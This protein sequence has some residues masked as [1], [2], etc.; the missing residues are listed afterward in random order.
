[1]EA[2]E[3]NE[4]QV[5]TTESTM[6]MRRRG[7]LIPRRDAVGRHH[8]SLYQLSTTMAPLLAPEYL[9]LPQKKLSGNAPFKF[10]I[11][12]NFYLGLQGRSLES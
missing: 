10:M 5:E 6:V 4:K 1:M 12:F 3:K 11:F 7:R 8:D 9:L 2:E